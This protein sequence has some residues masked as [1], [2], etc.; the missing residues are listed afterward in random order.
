MDAESCLA[1]CTECHRACVEAL[2]AALADDRR[3]AGAVPVR[4]LMD[5]ADISATSADFLM[6]GSEMQGWVGGVCA[7][8]C[9]ACADACERVGDDP[10]MRRCIDACRRCAEACRHMAQARIAAV[11]A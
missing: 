3:R 8:V 1:A 10:R 9:D 6:R 7:Q 5:C 2:T 4:L 11:V